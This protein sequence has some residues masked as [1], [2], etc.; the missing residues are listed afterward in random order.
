MNLDAQPS[1]RFGQ[2]LFNALLDGFERAKRD[3]NL[4]GGSPSAIG[5]PAVC[6]AGTSADAMERGQ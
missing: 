2:A 4:T 3:A 5:V 6:P 1:D